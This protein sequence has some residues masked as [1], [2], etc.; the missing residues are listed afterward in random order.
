MRNLGRRNQI[1]ENAARTA[2]V[3]LNIAEF[4]NDIA[5]EYQALAFHP[6]AIFFEIA[7]ADQVSLG[8]T[9]DVRQGQFAEHFIAELVV[10]ANEPRAKYKSLG[11]FLGNSLLKVAVPNRGPRE[12]DRQL[13]SDAPELW[14][15]LELAV[16]SDRHVPRADQRQRQEQCAE[17]KTGKGTRERK[18]VHGQNL[19]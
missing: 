12:D 4:W 17:R 11:N 14:S 10:E 9:N 18:A 6:R 5:G 2:I 16:R 19:K 3:I 8:A 7:P 1:D 15:D 13:L